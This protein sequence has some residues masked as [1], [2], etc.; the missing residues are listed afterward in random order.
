MYRALLYSEDRT[1]DQRGK[2]LACGSIR[3]DASAL[4]LNPSMRRKRKGK[5]RTRVG[6]GSKGKGKRCTAYL[7]ASG[8]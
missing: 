4:A 5:A 8:I 2:R 7:A 6:K 1:E 3:F